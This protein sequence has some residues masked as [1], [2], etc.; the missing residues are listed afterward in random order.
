MEFYKFDVDDAKCYG[1]R[2]AIVL[3]Y[4]IELLREQKTMGAGR[5]CGRI[6]V[7][8]TM[9]QL[10]RHFPFLTRKQMGLVLFHL[11]AYGAIYQ[12]NKN[13]R[14]VRFY[15]LDKRLYDKY[16]IDGID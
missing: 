3:Y 5:Y 2:E 9:R 1:V 6:V 8:C 12:I 10:L 7:G 14:L 15:L 4:L 11:C 13:T 16:D